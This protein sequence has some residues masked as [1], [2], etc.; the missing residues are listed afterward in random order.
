[1]SLQRIHHLYKTHLNLDER[2]VTIGQQILSLTGIDPH[3]SE[4][5]MPGST[6]GQLDLGLHDAI[7]GLLDVC[8]ED[9]RLGNLFIPMGCQ[10]N[11]GQ[12]ALFGQHNVSVEHVFDCFTLILF[13]SC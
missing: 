5:Q 12:R 10:P 13:L 3:D 7:D 1:M 2:F 4:Q 11:S 6:Q 9:V 8:F